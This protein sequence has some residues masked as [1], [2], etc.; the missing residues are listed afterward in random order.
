MTE[1][2]KI[3][4]IID[5]NSVVHRAFHALPPL[6]TKKG[7]VVNAVYGFLLVFFKAIKEFHPEY[8]VAAFDLP[9]PTFRHERY[10][11]Y[12][13]KRPP[14]PKELYE[15]IPKVKEVLKVFN[16]PI[17]EKQGFEADDIIGTISSQFSK[18]GKSQVVIL[19][20]DSDVL[21]LVNENTKAFI[22]RRG[23]KDTV[24]Y[25]ERMVQEKY[26]GLSPSQL[27]EYKAL[28]GDA[29]D[30]IPGVRGI[31]EKTAISL[32]K[33]FKNIDN[34]YSS[35]KEDKSLSES[36]RAK[37]ESQKE[38]AFLSRELSEIKKDV[39]IEIDPEKYSWKDYDL[40][41]AARMLESLDFYSLIPRL[42][43]PGE[44]SAPEDGKFKKEKALKAKKEEN[45]DNLRLW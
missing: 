37:L 9:F 34:L 42:P 40:A 26:Q 20:G 1:E 10:K 24:L 45:K 31:G 21:Q 25:D 15:Q 19:S 44:E 6:S 38:Q 28:R 35:L 33:Q 30:N 7:E 12:K 39:P 11:D 4:A 27:N 8:V 3:L 22:L 23:V 13:A 18:G 16:V 36:V 29:S 5:G 43:V 2:R 14:A 32:I 17:L 41:A